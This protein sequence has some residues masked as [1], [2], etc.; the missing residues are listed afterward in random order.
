MDLFAI[1]GVSLSA[2]VQA[3]SGFLMCLFMYLYL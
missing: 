2:N 1:V 3:S